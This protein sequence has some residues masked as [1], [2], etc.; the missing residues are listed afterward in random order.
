MR[1]R[2]L[3]GPV[4][5]QLA[6]HPVQR[7]PD[8]AAWRDHLER[9]GIAALVVTPDPVKIATE[10]A[11]WG[12]IKAHGLLPDTVILSDARQQRCRGPVRPGSAR[13]VL[14]ACRAARAQAR[15]VHGSATRRPAAG[16]RPDR[17][18]LR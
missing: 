6:A 5:A 15:H 14:G 8:E 4:I 1:Q 17:V 11:V 2:D 18:V 3:A 12:S 13:L 9:L 10:G 7:F 16:A